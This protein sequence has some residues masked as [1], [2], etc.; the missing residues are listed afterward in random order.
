[1]RTATRV[2]AAGFLIFFAAA[3]IKAKVAGAGNPGGLDVKVLAV[4]DG[5]HFVI[6]NYGQQQGAKV[7]TELFVK[8]GDDQIAEVRISQVEPNTSIA[9]VIAGTQA[10]GIRP[11]P[12]DRATFP[13]S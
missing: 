11:Q 9:D 8:R 7:N 10:N 6:L 5:W 4:N 3:C 2:A 1:M 12:G 13:G